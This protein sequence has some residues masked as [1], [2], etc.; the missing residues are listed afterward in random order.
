LDFLTSVLASTT[1]FCNFDASPPPY[2]H[3]LMWTAL[4]EYAWI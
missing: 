1:S 2:E 3:R 4:G